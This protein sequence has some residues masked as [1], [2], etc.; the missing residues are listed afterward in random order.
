MNTGTLYV[1]PLQRDISEDDHND[2][3]D[4][5]PCDLVCQL[6]QLLLVKIYIFIHY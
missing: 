4:D 3:D 6:C 1:R 2:D 5:D